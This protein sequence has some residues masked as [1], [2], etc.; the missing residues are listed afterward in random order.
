MKQY[1]VDLGLELTGIDW[2][3]RED[4]LVFVVADCMLCMQQCCSSPVLLHMAEHKR[5]HVVLVAQ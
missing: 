4:L 2:A 3:L 5:H 1:T